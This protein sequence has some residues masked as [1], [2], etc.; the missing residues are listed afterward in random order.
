[1]NLFEFFSKLH[2]KKHI[3]GWCETT[4]VFTGRFEQAALRGKAG[5][6]IADY[7]T[8]ELRYQ[9]EGKEQRG[10]YSFYP[11]PDPDASAIKDTTIRIRY[12]E[13]KPFVFE[14]ADEIEDG[15]EYEIED[16]MY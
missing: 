4:A 2:Q 15:I 16:D 12:N 10:W 11:L 1:M 5:Y 7:N 14:A 8:Y 3:K 9:A 13:K 6:K